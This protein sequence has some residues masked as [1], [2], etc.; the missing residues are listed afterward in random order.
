MIFPRTTENNRLK[1]LVNDKIDS[2]PDYYYFEINI[3]ENLDV[4]S[5]KF[6]IRWK[7]R[8]HFQWHFLFYCPKMTR[9]S[10]KY[11]YFYINSDRRKFGIWFS[12]VV[13]RSPCPLRWF[14]CSLKC[15]LFS[16]LSLCYFTLL[17]CM[18]NQ[19]VHSL[20][21]ILTHLSLALKVDS[22]QSHTQHYVIII[23]YHRFPLNTHCTGTH[24]RKKK[25]TAH[26]QSRSWTV[27]TKRKRELK[28]QTT[29]VVV[30]S[31]NNT[32]RHLATT[33]QT[34]TTENR[35]RNIDHTHTTWNYNAQLRN[36]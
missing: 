12:R 25:S 36:I 33:F 22:N 10:R 15:K 6:I 30:P 11:I 20:L 7:G 24:H 26:N 16:S 4:H 17:L 8:F 18:I 19:P 13:L 31:G 21:T 34:W 5:L 3:I 32:A 29:A 2:M 14:T 35:S 27:K 28:G 23:Q 9:A 1:A